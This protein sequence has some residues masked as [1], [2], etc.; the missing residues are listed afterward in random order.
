MSLKQG[1]LK[2]NPVPACEAPLLFTHSPKRA[3]IACGLITEDEI[4]VGA[5]TRNEGD[6]YFAIDLDYLDYVRYLR[7]FSAATLQAKF[8]NNIEQD[9]PVYIPANSTESIVTRRFSDTLSVRKEANEDLA[10]HRS[11]LRRDDIS[12]S[13]ELEFDF[14]N[15]SPVAIGS[16]SIALPQSA[17]AVIT[18]GDIEYA[19]FVA[20]GFTAYKDQHNFSE[21]LLFIGMSSFMDCL[22]SELISCPTSITKQFQSY[23]ATVSGIPIPEIFLLT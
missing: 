21:P 17:P 14:L 1:E 2:G 19:C 9:V 18:S 16:V 12:W 13:S 15:Q 4:R 20:N 8:L 3:G 10:N 5:S 23:S 6:P 11:L 7:G 22:Y